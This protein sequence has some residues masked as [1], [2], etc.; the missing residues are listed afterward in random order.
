MEC[1]KT[2]WTHH[3]ACSS[4]QLYRSV[5]YL[6]K[7]RYKH[8]SILEYFLLVWRFYESYTLFRTNSCKKWNEM[9]YELTSTF[10]IWQFIDEMAT[11][12]GLK[13]GI[14]PMLCTALRYLKG[15]SSAIQL[16]CSFLSYLYLSPSPW[17][18]LWC[19]QSGGD[20]LRDV[21]QWKYS[22]K[23]NIFPQP[24]PI[25]KCEIFP[26]A[27]SWTEFL[28]LFIFPPKDF[29]DRTSV[30]VEPTVMLSVAW[31]SVFKN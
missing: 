21:W 27:D 6:F 13:S 15:K 9:M 5:Y 4:K 19:V 3:F 1:S 12:A 18:R 28:S 11:A 2:S 10:I 22:V 20:L 31:K 7:T 16:F 17:I 26:F 23:Y 25:W 29:R 24:S 8:C 30:L 14:D